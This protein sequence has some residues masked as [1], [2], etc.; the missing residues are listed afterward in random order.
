[1][2]SQICRC[3]FDGGN[4]GTSYFVYP[5]NDGSCLQSIRQKVFYEGLNDMRAL[6]A[7]EKLIGRR[8]TMD[9]LSLYYGKVDFHTAAGSA[10]KLLGFREAL[11]REIEIHT[12]ERRKTC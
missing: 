3:F 2:Y 6:L 12:A 5:E 4:P 10:D 8:K 9:F 11:N 1:M 7:L